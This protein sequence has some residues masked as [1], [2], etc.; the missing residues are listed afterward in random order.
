M[1]F[2]S[3]NDYSNEKRPEMELRKA[4]AWY[5]VTY[6]KGLNPNQKFL[7]FPWTMHDLLCKILNHK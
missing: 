5:R 3:L 4:S 2:E 6:S 1:F 7:S